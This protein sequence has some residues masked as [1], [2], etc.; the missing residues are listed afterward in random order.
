[1]KAWV[2]ED[3][4]EFHLKDIEKPVPGE[5]WVNVR[6]KAA[7]ICGS[8]IQR[9]YENGA[10]RMPLVIGHEFSG[11]VESVGK[12]V[13]EAWIGKR[14]GI[15]PLIPCR[16]CAACLSKKYEMCTGYSYLGS[17]TDGGFA[18]YVSVPEWNLVELPENVSLEQAAMLEP[19]AVAVHAMRRLEIKQESTVAVCG[20]GTIGQLLIMFLLERGIRN[21]YAIGKSDS[22]RASVLEL[23]LS[24]RGFCDSR[25]VEVK[26]Y[27]NSVTE[28]RGVDAYFDCVG[29]NETVALGYEVT[30]PGG[31]VCMVGNPYSDMSFS[32]DTYWKLLRRQ[33]RITG[34]WN[35][36][37]LGEAD[38]EAG[39]DDWHYVVNRLKEGSVHPEKL[40]THRFS[41]EEFNRG[42]E[43]MREKKEPFVKI[44]MVDRDA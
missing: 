11:Q 29:K 25:T 9:V 15:F 43:I 40:I 22:Q 24:D 13:S 39:T 34:T 38:E 23:G 5:G 14:V 7:G 12:H 1:M 2:L 6:V 20:L 10:H 35:S 19:M 21:I 3:I 37:Y 44:L 16:Q 33:L 41:M 31:Q 18:E 28:S 4:G 27:L 36:S 42:F 8:D 32:K 26:E 30:A 17:R